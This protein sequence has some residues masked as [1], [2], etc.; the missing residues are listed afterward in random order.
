PCWR[1]GSG[2]GVDAWASLR[3]GSRM[4]V[5][6]YLGSGTAGDAPT[7][8][9]ESIAYIWGVEELP[10]HIPITDHP[11]W[12]TEA[13]G[14]A[15]I[16]YMKPDCN[17]VTKS[18]ICTAFLLAR[19]INDPG[20]LAMT[21]NHCIDNEAAA[22]TIPFRWFF[23]TATSPLVQTLG[24]RLLNN[25]VNNDCTLLALDQRPPNGTAFLP[26]DIGPWPSDQSVTG[27]H[28]PD[29]AFKRISFGTYAGSGFGFY[30]IC[31]SRTINHYTVTYTAGT[32]EGGSSG[33]PLFDSNR[34]VR[35]P[36]TGN[37]GDMCPPWNSSYGQ[38]AG[39]FSNFQAYLTTMTNPI[40]L[41]ASYG[42]FEVGN[43]VQPFRTIIK[44]AA[45]VR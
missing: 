33:S 11:E 12:A 10:C 41:D 8:Q 17:G 36:L 31:G 27:I 40:W 4:G 42:G 25:H 13:S 14:V 39:A 26:Y 18:F 29:G 30:N 2:G 28:H 1:A 44:A 23:D 37:D 7:P 34:R 38:F 35:G 45:V 16:D 32:T 20:P 22:N 43:S 24:A 5:E 21:A 9:I 15:K 6:F 19:T 3:A